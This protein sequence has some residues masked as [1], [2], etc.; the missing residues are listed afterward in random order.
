MVYDALVNGM[1]R[2]LNVQ[3]MRQ[4]D[5]MTIEQI[6]IPSLV[7]M[8]RAA[9]AVAEEIR[10]HDGS[11]RHV[12]VVAGKGNNGGDG[13]AVGRILAE[14]GKQV[15]F[16]LPMG[17]SSQETI[18]QKAMI[19]HLGFSICDK[20]QENEYDIIIDALLGIGASGDCLRE[21]YLE[22][23]RKINGHKKNGARIY[24]V[25]MPTGIQTDTGKIMGE[26]V[27]A[28]VT[29]TFQ[30]RKKAHVLYPGRAC[31]GEVIRKNIGIG[32]YGIG[33]QTAFSYYMEDR[34]TILPHR[35]PA[36]HKGSFGKVFLYAGS[37]EQSGAALLCAR[38]ILASGAGMLKVYTS[39]QNHEL[40][41]S[42]LP[43]AMLAF[44]S[45]EVGWA[46]VIVA[47]PGIGKKEHA[48]EGLKHLLMSE[49]KPMVLDADAI[50]LLS[51]HETLR[52]LLKE[53]SRKNNGQVVL[54]PH[55]AELVRL[56]GC[57]M[58]QYQEN[59]E[60]LLREQ[61]ARF[62]VVLASKDASTM[63]G[64]SKTPSFYINASGNN[65]MATAGSGDVLTGVIG[66]LIAQGF[67]ALEAACKGVFLHGMAGD[68]AVQKK[69]VY[70]MI[71]SDLIESLWEYMR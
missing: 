58:E 59:R 3:E 18:R 67:D 68:L 43:E 35:D 12:L 37:D 52:T 29:I 7:L 57:S 2:I 66:S 62:R 8:E 69:G 64:S 70:G 27:C 51:E 24:A 34:K 48:Y 25:D 20:W 6:G 1:D 13:L 36:G 44:S 4:C 50:N 61:I 28:D 11:C 26:A 15:T 16:F 71:A 19:E 54:T 10:K 53:F 39:P 22:I 56:A 45:E 47:G 14:Y 46:D 33:E 65:G 9:V 17:A 38:A 49:A 55:P 5:K 21:E 42:L 41:K 63:V 32:A 40:F 23:V 31:C 60:Q 30:Y